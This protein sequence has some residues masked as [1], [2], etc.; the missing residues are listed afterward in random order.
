MM[1]YKL[2]C[3]M[4]QERFEAQVIT[5]I[6]GGELSSRIERLGIPVHSLGVSRTAPNLGDIS[7]LVRDLRQSQPNLIQTWMYQ[8]DL[9]GGVLGK[10]FT[11]API[12][13]NIRCSYPDWAGKRTLRIAQGCAVLSP[14]IPAR[15]I[16]GSVSALNDHLALGYK[17]E[18]MVVIPNGFDLDRFRPDAA[19]RLVVREELQLAP[20]TKLVGLFARFALV[21]DPANFV[22]AA[23]WLH[24]TMPDVHFVMCGAEMSWEHR[25]LVEWIE[26]T[27]VRERFHLL[28]QRHDVPRWMAAMDVIVLSS[29][30]EG[31]PNVLG[32]AM[33]CGVPCV[34]TDTGDAALIVGDTGKV[35]PRKDSEKLA[36]ACAALLRLSEE[37]R[38]QLGLA[39]RRRIEEHYSLPTIV[40]QYEQLYEEL[41]A[42]RNGKH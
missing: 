34:A 22:R 14:L 40:H 9:A 7:K 16:C 28:G 30:S 2:L 29:E 41:L 36:E 31:F 19:A 12:I 17:K 25:Q 10:L 27:G 13:W 39:A 15:I 3:G 4:D 32:E 38:R 8:S 11:G 37:D 6:K 5:L 35:V 20:E 1:L 23:A 33:A 18:K 21:K 24:R 26:Q 42:P